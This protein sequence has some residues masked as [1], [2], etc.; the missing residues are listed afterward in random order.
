[1]PVPETLTKAPF[2]K[3]PENQHYPALLAKIGITNA[4]ALGR[5]LFKWREDLER[6]C[7]GYKASLSIASP[8]SEVTFIS[9]VTKLLSGALQYGPYIEGLLKGFLSALDGPE[10]PA[11]LASSPTVPPGVGTGP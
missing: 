4:T 1:M 2:F 9:S 7:E 5:A 6:Q 3:K 8:I 11:P 10:T